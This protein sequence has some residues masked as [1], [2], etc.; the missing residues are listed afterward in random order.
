MTE[1]RY[2]SVLHRDVTNLHPCFNH[3]VR[4]YFNLYRE[5][6]VFIREKESKGSVYERH[7][8]RPQGK[9]RMI[10]ETC[11]KITGFV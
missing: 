3:T 1:F 5:N 4:K 6:L 7:R 11:N 2:S 8:W 9:D 10:E